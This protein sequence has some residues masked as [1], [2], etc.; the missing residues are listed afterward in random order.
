M[1]VRGCHFPDGKGKGPSL[2]RWSKT[3][4]SHPTY[5]N[6][7]SPDHTDHTYCKVAG[8]PNP[9][10]DRG[11]MEEPEDVVC[12]ECRPVSGNTMVY[13]PA[14][15]TDDVIWMETGLPEKA[16]VRR[17][18]GL[19]QHFEGSIFYAAGWRVERMATESHVFITLMKVRQNYT[20]LHLAQL[21]CCSTATVANVV[22]T[23]IHLLHSLLFKTMM[24]AVPSRLNRESKPASFVPPASNCRIIIDCTDIQVAAPKEM[25]KANG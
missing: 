1:R 2:F 10:P 5:T 20:H 21:F 22:K 3:N 16:M 15:L 19:V 23:C 8:W 11:D 9:G 24:A 14:G 6:S 7:Q 18:V 4:P 13:S 12:Q 17:V 25:D